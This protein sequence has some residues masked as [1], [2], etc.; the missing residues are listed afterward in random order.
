ME[1]SRAAGVDILTV[2]PRVDS[3][4]APA[5][6]NTLNSLLAGGSTRILCDFS[7]TS[8]ISSAGL[9][10]LLS[11]AKTLMR[12]RGK[13]ALCSLRPGVSEIIKIAG[14]NQIIP[15]F[16]SREPAIFALSGNPGP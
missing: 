16:P 9:R 11:V 5:L 4:S 7:G 14:I 1:F 12:S 6:E 3:D 10:V 8:Y 2:M 15:V 13:I